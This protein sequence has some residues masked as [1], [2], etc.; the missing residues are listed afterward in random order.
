[1]TRATARVAAAV[2]SRTSVRSGPR[3]VPSRS[4]PPRGTTRPELRLVT[5]GA[6]GRARRRTPRALRHPRAPFVL[7]VVA[8]LVGTT[9]ALLV[10]NTAIAVDSLKATQLRAENAERAQEVQ[11]LQ[12]QVVAGGTPAEIARAAVAAGLVPAG[13]AA[14]L[15]IDPDGGSVLRGTPEPAVVPGTP[16][17]GD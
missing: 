4:T 2:T 1:M 14:Y 7:L 15:V 11:R 3:A 12:Q 16:E 10:L 17:D 13:P 6:A 8:L 5:G 9:L